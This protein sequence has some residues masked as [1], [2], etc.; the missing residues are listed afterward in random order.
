MADEG[1]N[2]LALSIEHSQQIHVATDGTTTRGYE[3]Y[4]REY[5]GMLESGLMAR[6]SN[7]AYKTLHALALRARI[8]GDPRR[9]GAEEEFRELVRLG[10]VSH[11]DK[12]L[13]FCFP[14]R[15]RL[16][17]D[18]G[19][20]SVHTVDAAL[21]ELAEL[22][23]VKRITPAQPRL[24]RGLFG[25]N[26]YIIHPE[27][28]IG[29]FGAVDGE[30]KVPPDHRVDGEQKMLPDRRAD[31]EQKVL[32]A[33]VT[34]SS[35]RNSVNRALKS[36]NGEHQQEEME[37]V[38]KHFAAS[39]GIEGYEPSEKERRKI[40][41]L[42]AEGHTVEEICAGITRTVERA[43][44][45]GRK[46]RSIAYCL[47]AVRERAIQEIER[48]AEMGAPQP[49][50]KPTL[51]AVPGQPHAVTQPNPESRGESK[52]D[53][54]KLAAGDAEL[55][56]LLEIVQ[57]RNPGRA[58]RKSDVRA[59]QAVAERF[60]DLAT[61]RDTTPIGLVMQAVLKGIGANSDRD[62]FFAPALAAAI[63]EN[64]QRKQEEEQ[65][66]RA[67]DR[68]ASEPNEQGRIVNRSS[69]TLPAI[70]T[71][72]GPLD[73]AQIWDAAVKELRGQMTKATFDTW[74]KPTFVADASDGDAQG[75][76]GESTLVI[77]T[78]NQHAVEWL[79][80]RL[81]TTIQRTVVGIVGKHITVKYL[82]IG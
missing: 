8:L 73:P 32:P 15:E 31:G 42:L 76:R 81:H 17:Q 54:E 11:E 64:W 78:R 13:L 27:S 82:H 65:P 53:L 28:F 57:E 21:D 45:A 50:R 66:K 37:I 14:S 35:L 25:S 69:K 58:L 26:I 61:A 22:K 10:I 46:V 1:L 52:D 68:Q 79:E 19:M 9:L 2:G 60:R 36:N 63:L 41:A 80:H 77:G 3:T 55:R 16:M 20:G 74:V 59:W 4:I 62:G 6:L 48:K 56:D 44:Q 72:E 40:A 51:A 67:E 70:Q 47:P 49:N 5:V 71:S 12:G 29:K 23:I 33:E 43:L 39:V 30:Q 18:T 34:G 7:A 75:H 38:S 24:T